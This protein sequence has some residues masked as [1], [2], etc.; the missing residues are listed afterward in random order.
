MALAVSSFAFLRVESP[1]PVPTGSLIALVILFATATGSA[2]VFYGY[3]TLLIFLFAFL[4]IDYMFL[5]DAP[6]KYDPDYKNWQ[7]QQDK[8]QPMC[9]V[10]KY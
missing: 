1:S 10:K 8:A 4:L 5:D 2:G 7:R 9:I 3:V 6:F